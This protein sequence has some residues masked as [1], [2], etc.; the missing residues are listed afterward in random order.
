[1]MVY[2]PS[3]HF[4][5]SLF[6]ILLN[7]F[8][9]SAG[10]HPLLAQAHAIWRNEPTHSN[11]IFM[12]GLVRY[13]VGHVLVSI[14]ILES[15]EKQALG[16]F[17]D[18]RDKK[19]GPSSRQLFQTIATLYRTGNLRLLLNGIGS[20]CSYWAKHLCTK[21][22]L[23]RAIFLPRPVAYVVASVLLAEDRF[24]WNARTILPRDQQRFVPNS[25]DRQRWK[26]LVPATALHAVA[27]SFMMHFPALFKSD[28]ASSASTD[29]TKAHLSGIVGFEILVSG[30]MLAA[31]FLLLFPSFIAL[32]LVQ[33]SL[34][35]SVCETLVSTPVNP[36]GR[37]QQ[38]GR[39]V[40]EIF[41]AFNRVSL[42]VQ[43][44]VKII[45]ATYVL[46][47]VELHAKMCLCL[48]GVSAVV[49]VAIYDMK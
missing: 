10:G 12:S 24:L 22:M 48:I 37:Q 40:G 6:R 11:N 47:C 44:V 43:E 8:I 35:P 9:P 36:G 30:V 46:W 15:V 27:E 16:S 49:Q 20:A 25:R 45:G 23:T 38:R 18:L 19:A 7:T 13:I 42:R 2:V 26:A 34:L 14:L 21:Q 32:V 41:A 39:R 3:P 4:L 1:M 28:L 33:T 31:Q 5:L 29:V 17:S